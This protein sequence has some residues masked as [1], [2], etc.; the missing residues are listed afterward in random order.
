MVLTKENIGNQM[1]EGG[2][3]LGLCYVRLGKATSYLEQ[4]WVTY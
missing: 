1:S 4:E 3:A 2:K